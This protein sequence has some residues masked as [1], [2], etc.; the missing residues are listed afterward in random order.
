MVQT[1]PDIE[2]TWVG[3]FLYILFACLG[4]G[5]HCKDNDI[6]K[7]AFQGMIVFHQNRIEFDTESIGND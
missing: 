5:L 2:L 7:F 4:Y 6:W 3:K 1:K